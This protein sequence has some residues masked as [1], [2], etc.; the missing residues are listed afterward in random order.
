MSGENIVPF[1][2]HERIRIRQD[3]FKNIFETSISP[4]Y[5][6]QRKKQR[7]TMK[8][9]RSAEILSRRHETEQ[10]TSYEQQLGISTRKNEIKT[11]LLFDDESLLNMIKTLKDTPRN[12]NDQQAM[13][14]TYYGSYKDQEIFVSLVENCKQEWE[15]D[16][17][18]QK[19]SFKEYVHAKGIE[20]IRQNG[21]KI[22]K[23]R[24]QIFMEENRG[25]EGLS[26]DQRKQEQDKLTQSLDA[27]FKENEG[28]MAGLN[29]LDDAQ[30]SIQRKMLVA[31]FTAMMAQNGFEKTDQAQIEMLFD[32]YVGDFEHEFATL[33]EFEA[34]YETMVDNAALGLT[35]EEWEK[36]RQE[37][38][39]KNAKG[40]L[41]EYLQQQT[42][43]VFTGISESSPVYSSLREVENACGVHFEP[44]GAP[45]TYRIKAPAVAD[46]AFAPL[47]RIV[48]DPPD[49]RTIENARFF[50]QQPWQDEDAR[51]MGAPISGAEGVPTMAYEPKEAVAGVN[52]AILDWIMNKKIN[53]SLPENAKQGTNRIVRGDLMVHMAERLLTPF[54]VG[55]RPIREDE[56]KTFQRFME[57]VL[58]DDSA[59]EY[60]S[61]QSRSRKAWTMIDRDA[62]LPYLKEIFSTPGAKVRTLS[63][64]E[65][66]IGLRRGGRK[67]ENG[68]EVKN[69]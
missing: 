30:K 53:L 68:K 34:T 29:S 18:L 31:K 17:V 59:K 13:R 24:A 64:L 58:R 43:L 22:R 20:Y 50:I 37:A 39:K 61:L 66:E 57:V 7:E 19:M 46:N 63:E 12:E 54:K 45:D 51:N 55:E 15:A 60:D 2:D 1:T 49:S 56:A 27:F 26:D 62:D 32:M 3:R 35:P 69:P 36:R 11:N 40:E 52:T 38:L 10:L 65:Q 41:Q 44:A 33:Q 5:L 25:M 21:D 23:A 48:Y 8:S 6:A 47:M 42:G 16:P 67:P 14:E 4:L 9:I 28:A